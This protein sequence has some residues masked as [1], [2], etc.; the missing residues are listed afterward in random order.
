M[1]EQKKSP[2]NSNFLWLIAHEA[3]CIFLL[4]RVAG[5]SKISDGKSVLMSSGIGLTGAVI[6]MILL[7]AT[8]SLPAIQRA[9][10]LAILFVAAFFI[11]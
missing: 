6:G 4:L 9:A 1:T 2:G 7:R 3:V 11:R 10:I 5:Y 8:S